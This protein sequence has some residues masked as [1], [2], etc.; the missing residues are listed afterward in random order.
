M[1]FCRY[2]GRELKD[3]ETCSCQ[4]QAEAPKAGAGPSSDHREPKLPEPFGKPSWFF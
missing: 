1:A 2:C 3:G 4:G